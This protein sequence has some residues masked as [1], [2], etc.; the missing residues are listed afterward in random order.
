MSNLNVSIDSSKV[1]QPGTH[2]KFTEPSNLTIVQKYLVY[3]T[4]GKIDTFET[5]QL[6][7]N[8]TNKDP[9]RSCSW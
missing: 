4:S 6:E 3:T 7:K 2:F 8:S 1:L 5:V 9:K